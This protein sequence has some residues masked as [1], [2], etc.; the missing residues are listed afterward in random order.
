MGS[1]A[2]WG[3][4]HAI[5]RGFS[6]ELYQ[7]PA[8]FDPFSHGFAALFVLGAATVSGLLVKRDLDRA[9]LISVLKTRD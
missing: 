6:S 4:S 1:L 7:I 8:T 5:A 9:D 2:G 3:L